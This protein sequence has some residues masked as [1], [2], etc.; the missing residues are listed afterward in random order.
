MGVIIR[1]V[2][3]AD[4]S[5]WLSLWEGYNRFY[6]RFDA[7]A[8]PEAT[9]QMTWS[10]FFD[11]YEP[12]HAMVAEVDGRLVGLA[13][14]LFHRSTIAIEPSCY[15]Q[16]L[17][18]AETA[19][20]KGVGRMLIEA[21]YA[22]ARLEGVVNVYWRT[23]ASNVTARRLYDSVAENSGFLVYKKRLE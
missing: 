11:A 13:H 9:T 3:H 14:Y 23:H 20:R 5:E 7:T 2:T 10:R 21:V 19:R 1:F 16:D 18:T 4:Y 17:F 15:L 8:L 22:Q 12:V 6:G